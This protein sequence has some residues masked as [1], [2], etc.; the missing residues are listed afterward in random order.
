MNIFVNFSKN[1]GRT[2]LK[3]NTHKWPMEVYQRVQFDPDP[4]NDPD[5]RADFRLKIGH[6]QETVLTSFLKIEA[7]DLVWML[8]VHSSFT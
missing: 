8:I 1:N 3:K 4:N 2:G 7:S 5:L 6:F